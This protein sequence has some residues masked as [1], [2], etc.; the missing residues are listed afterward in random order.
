MP[1]T[2][3]Q[4]PVRSTILDPRRNFAPT[5]HDMEFRHDPLSG[6]TSRLAH[7]GAVSPVPLNLSVYTDER[8]GFCPFCPP[9][10]EKVTPRFPEELIP[11]GFIRRSEAALIA[12]IAPYDAYSGLIILSGRHLLP[13]DELTPQR[14]S[15]ALAL[16]FDFL[17]Y[18]RRFDRNIPYFFLGWNYMPPSGGGLV[19]PHLQA[20]GSINPGN[21]FL[22]YLQGTERYR[23]ENG[24]PFW[25]DLIA[26]V[27]QAGERYLA[28]I[29]GIHW[30]TAYAP[31]GILGD[32]LAVVSG[33]RTPDEAEDLTIH[34]IV[35]G[36]GHLFSYYRDFGVFSFNATFH[37]APDN[38]TDFPLIIRFSA[39][40]YLNSRDFPP[41]ANFFQMLLQ[42]PM[43]VLKPEDMAR[44]IRPHFTPE[45]SPGS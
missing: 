26:A 34:S 16:A 37:F 20:F 2:F 5:V 6:R 33:V 30:L 31:L 45:S 8:K 18:V 25:P 7:F 3:R 38:V 43:C 29:A 36:L 32:V 15:D 42:Q 14:L 39:R 40:T 1:I 41:D 11:G 24:R 28:E 44:Q 10:L 23:Q 35:T 17:R 22:E 19:H 27:I 21:I 9:N 12:N 13:L 4:D